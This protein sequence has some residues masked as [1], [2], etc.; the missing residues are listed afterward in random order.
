MQRLREFYNQSL[1]FLSRLPTRFLCSV[2]SRKLAMRSDLNVTI[3][4]L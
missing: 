1:F 4:I 2:S 3:N